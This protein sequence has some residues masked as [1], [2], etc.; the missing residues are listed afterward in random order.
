MQ[1]STRRSANT[2]RA[3]W[4]SHIRAWKASGLSSTEYAAG[5][6]INANTLTWWQWRLGKDRAPE[7]RAGAR[8]RKRAPARRQR[9]KS[10]PNTAAFVEL[11]DSSPPTAPPAA[12][13]IELLL[14]G[15]VVRVPVDFDPDALSRILQTLEARR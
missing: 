9:K 8:A 15:V 6:G 2:S 3:E 14:A 7:N 4:Q 5:A 12:T 10:A 13:G 1:T 11:V